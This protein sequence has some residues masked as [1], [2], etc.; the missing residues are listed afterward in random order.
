MTSKASAEKRKARMKAWREANKDE[1]RAY[2]K[3][4]REANKDSVNAYQRAYQQDYRNRKDVRHDTWVRALRNNYN[5]TPAD[6]NLMWAEQGGICEICKTPMAPRGKAKNSV[7]VDHNHAT[8]EIRGLLCRECNQGLGHMK[9]DPK[10]LESALRYLL[11]KGH[12]GYDRIHI[13]G[14]K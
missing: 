8:G 11:N 6:F 3:Q 4:W 12:Y 10:V 2:Q 9:D 13:R 5:M 14:L 1:I 7:C